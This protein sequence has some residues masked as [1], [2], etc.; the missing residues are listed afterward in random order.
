MRF[1]KNRIDDI[2]EMGLLTDKTVLEFGCVGMGEDDEYGGVNWIHG[3]AVKVAKKVVGLDLNKEGVRKLRKLGYDIRL[4]NVEEKFD[5]HEK[6]DVVLVEEV[7][8]HLN[9]VGIALNNIRRHLKKNGYLIITTPHAQAVSFFLQRLFRN[10]I[11]GV[12]I[13]DHTH[14]YDENTLRT[15]LKRYNFKIRKSWYVQP[16]AINKTPLSYI[17]KFIWSFFP[18]RVGRNLVCIA[19]KID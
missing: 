17:L 4:Q 9:N 5:L 12:S 2:I 16:S 19:Q 10:E 7:F 8:E 14:W 13:T 3:R 15:L 6:F 1:T 18:Q 11:S